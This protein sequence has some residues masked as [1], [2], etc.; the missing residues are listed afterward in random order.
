[1]R[2]GGHTSCVEVRWA[3]EALIVLDCGT[4]AHGLGQSLLKSAR[5]PRPGH[6]LIGHTHWD[7]IQ[8][9]PFFAPLYVP[10]NEWHIYGPRGAELSLRQT[11]AGQMQYTYFPVTFEQLGATIHYHD[12][13]EGGFTIDDLQVTTHY[14]NHPALTLGYRL[15][16]DGMVLVYATDHE[17]YSSQLAMGE[18]RS[19]AGED[20][21]HV[22]FLAGADLLIHDAQYTAEEYPAKR[23]WGHSTIE[24]VVDTAL[25]AG[26]QCLVLFHH[27]PL[28][29]D[30]AVDRLLAGAR[31]RVQAVH[32][33]LEIIAAAEGQVLELKGTHAVRSAPATA[34]R[35]A[36]RPPPQALREQSVLVAVHDSA[37]ETV[38]CEAARPDGL[39]ILRTNT[40]AQALEYVRTQQPSL[41]ILE[42]GLPD[43]DVFEM[44]RVIR[45]QEGAYGK[46]VAIVVVTEQEGTAQQEMGTAAGV[47]DW[48]RKPFSSA[49]ARTRIRAWL[50]RTACHWVRAPLP[51]NEAQRLRGLH[52]LRLLDTASEERFN[53]YTRIAAELF[54]VPIALITLVDAERQWFKSRHGL[55]ISETPRDMAF[56]AHTILGS[57]VLLMPDVLAHAHFADNPLVTGTPYVRFYAGVSLTLADGNR[58][59]TLCVIDHRP[60][61]LNELQLQLLRDLGKLV[62]Q[63]LEKNA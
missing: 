44:C 3:D 28:R 2:Y 58:P 49:Y 24:Y 25:A 30:E 54:G 48:L 57:D 20:D 5:S 38:L 17:P 26:V 27:D 12:L 14:L 47:T 31:E 19:M 10:D 33:S 59:G 34:R 39:R 9:F 23:G 61:H 62:E 32:G 11:L 8:G 13:V 50:L 6:M 41:I 4:G 63:E 16:S 29:T 40:G 45:T 60:R 36:V 37:V 51:E 18:R 56:C 52:Q 35:S 22:R 21:A 1:V 53:R 7:H 55:E 46:E 42:Q 43:G 15:E